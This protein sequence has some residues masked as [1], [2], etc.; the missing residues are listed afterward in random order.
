MLEDVSS[1]GAVAQGKAG[2]KLSHSELVSR[3]ERWLRN[4]IG[5]SVVI[6]EM[7][8][9]AGEEADAIGWKNGHSFLVE[10]KKSRSDF[11]ADKKKMWRRNDIPSLGCYRFYMV[12]GD[13]ISLDELPYKW[14]LLS[15]QGR[16]VRRVSG[17]NEEQN[18]NP[19]LHWQNMVSA[20]AEILLLTSAL[21]R[22]QKSKKQKAKEGVDDG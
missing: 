1:G 13:L 3:A 12:E 17:Y 10:C 4:T 7:S 5:C 21:R 6:C 11:L 19:Q 18:C 22:Y 15:I 16:R 20:R 9:S 14:G 8:S 2:G